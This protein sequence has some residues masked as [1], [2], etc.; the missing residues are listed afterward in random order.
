MAEKGIVPITE[1]VKVTLRGTI[2][3]GGP[4]GIK[5]HSYTLRLPQKPGKLYVTC[6]F[7]G[8]EDLGTYYQA[9]IDV[10]DADTSLLIKRGYS[11]DGIAN[12]IVEFVM[13]P[14]PVLLEIYSFYKRVEYEAII[15]FHGE[16]PQPQPP[17]PPPTPEPEP[18]EEKF[19]LGK[20]LEYALRKILRDEEPPSCNPANTRLLVLI[21]AAVYTMTLASFN[22]WAG[23]LGL[24]AIPSILFTQPWRLFTYMW[25]H[26][27]ITATINGVLVPHAHIAFN[28]LF[29]WVFGDNVECRL[30]HGKYLAYYLIL[31]IIAGLGQ[32]LWLHIIG[33][34]LKPIIIIGASGAISG[35][36]GLYFSF[37]PRNHVI[38]FGKRMTAWTFLA[39]WF[40]GQIALLFSA[41][42]TVAVA[43]H[44]T[45]FLAGVVLGEAEKYAEREIC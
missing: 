18:P 33:E 32:V 25:L 13:P 23:I 6:K 41:S 24:T 43:A 37:F 2:D 10:R 34:G 5:H 7:H 26:A 30:G 15:R 35:I 16:T 8:F 11:V 29:L 1:G 40:I 20:W 19:N 45:G 17:E 3:P 42:G 12:V 22:E 36:M 14:K 9:F 21:L 31:G 28:T 39:L 44:V 38:C 4:S 27:P